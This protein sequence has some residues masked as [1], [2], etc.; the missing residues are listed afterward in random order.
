M[1][2]PF[3]DVRFPDD[4]AYGASGGPRFS[5]SV[6]M[7]VTGHEQRN[8]NWSMV[9]C[10]F[11]CS[12]TVKTRSQM[13]YLIEFFHAR[14]GRQRGFRF[15]D[16]SDFTITNQRIG[17]GDGTRVRWQIF[18]LYDDGL[19]PFARPVTKI[20][21]NSLTGI[22]VGGDP[23]DPED[24]TVDLDTGIVE[25]TD[26]PD[27]GDNINILYLEFDLPARFDTDEMNVSHD[28][29]ETMS[30]PSIPIVEIKPELTVPLDA[31]QIE[32][33][34][35][36]AIRMDDNISYGSSGGP[37]FSTTILTIT[38]GFEKRKQNWVQVR[39]EYDVAKA[40]R[41]R[42][43]MDD[44]LR[45][46]YCRRGR[47]RGFRY[48]DWND[49]YA[50][51]ATIGIGNGTRTVWQ[52]FKLYDGGAVTYARPITKPIVGSITGL[53]LNGV[54]QPTGWSCNH[55]TG[56]ITFN[57]AP[58]AGVVISIDGFE[59][60]V[61]VRFDTDFLNITHDFWET[62]SAPSIALAEIKPRLTV[63]LDS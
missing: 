42:E 25:F 9:R 2:S 38:S 1:T 4:I 43:Q 53:R 41:T 33:Q 40:V 28:G 37:Q 63:P 23:V 26:P 15:K 49:A 59:F 12:H 35:F 39:A 45:F 3:D 58:G 32:T 36:D 44:L 46:F 30:W 54:E 56:L 48:Y 5:T 7:T 62:M 10:E 52:L 21:A 51:N 61:P 19:A 31:P 6:L 8:Q 13:E 57:T 50:E 60:D 18:K 47:A 24:Y 14:R 34:A 29:W 55:E 27:D 20:V 11:E 16:W 22:T 17:T